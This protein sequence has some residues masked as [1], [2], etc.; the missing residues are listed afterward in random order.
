[1]RTDSSKQTQ[2]IQVVR[3]SENVFEDQAVIDA[4]ESKALIEVAFAGLRKIVAKVTQLSDDREFPVLGELP[5][6]M[7]QK[8][9]V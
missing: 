3:G 7:Y 1:M 9:D 2:S 5:H 6:S 4:D 8:D